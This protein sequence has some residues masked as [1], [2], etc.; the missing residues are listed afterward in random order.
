MRFQIGFVEYI[1]PVFIAQFVPAA[2]VRIVAVP[3]RIEVAGFQNSDIF[4]HVLFRDR[5]AS[6][7]V[8]LVMIDPEEFYASPV[9]EELTLADFHRTE[10]DLHIQLVVRSPQLQSIEIR[11][12]RTPRTDLHLPHQFLSG[13]H[14]FGE[15]TFQ[16][17]PDFARPGCPDLQ[18]ERIQRRPD[19]EVFDM[20]C[21]SG[22]EIH[23]AEDSGKPPH[24]LILQVGPV[25][26]A[27]RC[28]VET[29]FPRLK[30]GRDIELGGIPAAFG[31]TGLL[32]VHG[33]AQEGIRPLKREDHPFPPPAL[34]NLEFPAV[35][36][37]RIAVM[38]HTGRIRGKGIVDVGVD[39]DIVS[40]QFRMRGHFQ[41]VRQ[42]QFGEPVQ[43]FRRRKTAEGPHSAKIQFFRIISLGVRRK[44]VFSR[45]SR[46]FPV[47][48][49]HM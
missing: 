6:P 11:L 13:F 5:P 4:Q 14:F 36:G 43:I 34:R 2:P 15:N 41:P 25:G 37:N 44:F 24:I 8:E 42:G 26:P 48:H 32:P 19:L 7:A 29:V 47:E 12:F 1:Q 49:T 23:F 16:L 39:R 46:I 28:R 3:D 22:I 9:D 20:I 17:R 31:K 30:Q 18:P 21:P 40:V 35:H 10:S 45:H 27:Q 38:R 33:Y